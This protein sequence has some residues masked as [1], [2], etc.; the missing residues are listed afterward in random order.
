MRIEQ[1]IHYLTVCEEKN[2]GRASSN[3]AQQT[4]SN[5]IKGIEQTVNDELLIR[6]HKGIER[7][8]KGEI[9]YQYFREIVTLYDKMMDE[10][11]RSAPELGQEEIAIRAICGAVQNILPEFQ[12]EFYLNYPKTR[13]NIS[14]GEL[15]EI[16]E[17]VE[18]GRIDL[19]LIH[20]LSCGKRGSYPELSSRAFQIVP[21]YRWQPYVWLGLKNSLSRK[22]ALS[23]ANA[24]KYPIITYSQSDPVLMQ[25]FIEMILGEP[26]P[27]QTYDNLKTVAKLVESTS[28]LFFDWY[29]E[30]YGL[31]CQL[32]FQERAVKAIPV[33]LKT[34][35]L[36]D[37]VAIYP[38][39]RREDA[40]IQEA[41]RI[42]FAAAKTKSVI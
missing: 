22:N 36:L 3:M 39:Q 27:V 30:S 17:D 12:G 31:N 9:V 42:L 15:F 24:K 25:K 4:L 2:F 33:V 6:S 40:T 19:G 1:M 20:I 21:L 16:I 10:I 28:F 8:Y 11:N 7:T 35:V 34:P 41:V 38:D 32:F 37:T 23:I 29:S 14:Q 26:V 18:N 13:L 5:S